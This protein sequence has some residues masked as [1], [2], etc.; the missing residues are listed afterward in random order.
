MNLPSID[1]SNALV[2]ALGCI[3]LCGLGFVLIT[4][5]HVIGGVLGIFTSLLQSFFHILGGGPVAWCGC[6]VV[7]G[8]CLGAAGLALV[9]AQAM[10]TCGTPQAIN[11]C[12][13]L[14][15]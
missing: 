10:A 13:L 15:K 5:L 14:G 3:C 7:I 2:I 8:G 9:I 4:S 1:T 12:S 11:F 6:L